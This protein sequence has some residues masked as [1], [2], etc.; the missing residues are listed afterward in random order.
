MAFE[1]ILET[2]K[3]FVQCYT[4]KYNAKTDYKQS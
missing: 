2:L 4:I 3:P 1:L